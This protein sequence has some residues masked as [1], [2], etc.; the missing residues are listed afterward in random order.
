MIKR[1]IYNFSILN[2]KMIKRFKLGLDQVKI[3]KKRSQFELIETK[4]IKINL[5]P[6]FG[7]HMT[8]INVS[9]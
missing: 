4:S 2:F 6:N 8:W 3:I 1:A 5:Y 9:T 7:Q